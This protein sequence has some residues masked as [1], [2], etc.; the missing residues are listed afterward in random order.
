MTTVVLL[1]AGLGSRMGRYADVINKTLLPVDGQAI[2]SHVIKQFDESTKFVIAVGYKKEQVKS[3]IGAAHPNL[4]VTFVDVDNYSGVNSGPAYSLSLC[5]DYILEDF[6]V[7]ACD[8]LY[9]NLP[10][11]I[12]DADCMAVSRVTFGES[13]AYC[14]VKVEDGQV[15][16]IQDKVRSNFG[17]AFNGSFYVKTAHKFWKD[18]KG[19]E[20]SSGFRSLRM[21]ALEMEWIDLGTFEKYKKHISSNS[22]FDFSKD[23]EFIYFVNDRVVKWFKDEKTTVNRIVKASMHS[24]LFPKVTYHGSGFYS[25]T[26]IQGTT[27]YDAVTPEI[28]SKFISWCWDNIW[29]NRAH[30]NKED[31]EKFYFTKTQERLAAF[32][33]KYPEFRP[34]MINGKF[35]EYDVDEGLN[36]VDW[37]V[38]LNPLESRAKFMHGDLQLAN[39][40][41]ADGE[42]KLID[43]RQDFAGKIDAGDILYDAAKLKASL[44][45]DYDAICKGKFSYSEEKG[46]VKFKIPD[47]SKYQDYID[48]IDQHFPKYVTDQIVTIIYLNMA[49]LH[50][51]PFDKLLYCLALTRLNESIINYSELCRNCSCKVQC[52]GLIQRIL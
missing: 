52:S 43:W 30:L 31:L 19:Q 49:A 27:L 18:L 14:N 10:S 17:M 39:V 25:Y 9:Q 50:A 41:Y 3:Y 22:G 45:L 40:I 35:V 47:N 8:A 32:R 20:L 12:G 5:K 33:L 24:D 28:F 11:L 26:K 1:A 36:L 37:A 34:T 2:I 21:R 51:N 23:D 6:L 38:L 7:V 16:Q 42:F 48:L 46:E 29:I 44:I 15:R 13:A 4:N